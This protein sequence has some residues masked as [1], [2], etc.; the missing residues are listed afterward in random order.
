[1]KHL[2]SFVL[3]L[4][5]L[6]AFGQ[7]TEQNVGKSILRLQSGYTMPS[8]EKGIMSGSGNGVNFK[9]SIDDPI[10][11]RDN[12]L[13]GAGVTWHRATFSNLPHSDV[14]ANIYVFM[15][16][17]GFKHHLTKNFNSWIVLE[18]GG[19]YMQSLHQYDGLRYRTKEG[20]I[21]LGLEFGFDYYFSDAWG[22]CASLDVQRYGNNYLNHGS[23]TNLSE[24]PLN[25]N[26]GSLDLGVV[27]RF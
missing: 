5:S 23:N 16:R 21:A 1:M 18:F 19:A 24:K 8:S 17:T 4:L 7:V 26:P 12:W 27:Y 20:T 22:V 10:D 2:L 6:Q 25:F 14:P 15:C 3:C 9:L 13:L 11:K